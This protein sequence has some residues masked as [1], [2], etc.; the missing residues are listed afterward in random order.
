[1]MVVRV[2]AIVAY[3]LS[4]FKLTKLQWHSSSLPDMKLLNWNGINVCNCDYQC[5]W[6]PLQNSV[7]F[8]CLQS[9]NFC[10]TVSYI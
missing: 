3:L 2:I 5:A 7:V 9:F 1:M 8:T 6:D 4:N 10:V